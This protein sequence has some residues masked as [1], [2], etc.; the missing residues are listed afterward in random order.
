MT[1]PASANSQGIGRRRGVLGSAFTLI[2]LL[3]VIAIIAILAAMLLPALGRA[4]AKALR[5]QCMSNQHQ[6]GIALHNYSDDSG[7]FYPLYDNWATWGGGTGSNT[8]AIHGGGE[9][10]TNRVLNKYTGNQLNLYHCPADKGDVLRILPGDQGMSCFTAW[11]NSYLMAWADDRYRVTHVGGD[12]LDTPGSYAA[13]PI[14]SAR[15]AVRASNK[16]IL[17]DWPWFGDRDI[18]NPESAWHNDR[19]KP[20]FLMLFGDHHVENFLFP[21]HPPRTVYDDGQPGNPW[22]DPLHPAVTWW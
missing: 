22:G 4:K 8:Y 21:S 15:I 7:D 2:E 17:G 19:G 16:I 13:T 18:N 10:W 5:A 14:K 3:V 6:L 12:K 1:K 11:G 9:S 20:V